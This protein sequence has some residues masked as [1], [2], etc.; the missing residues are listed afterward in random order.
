VIEDADF[1]FDYEKLSYESME[2][3]DNKALKFDFD[4]NFYENH[5]T[6]SLPKDIWYPELPGPMKFTPSHVYF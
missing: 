4:G 3:V 5:F 6:S 2:V 1:S